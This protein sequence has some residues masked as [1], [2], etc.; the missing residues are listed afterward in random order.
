[1]HLEEMTDIC[2]KS[3]AD[4]GDNLYLAFSLSLI[5]GLSTIL[6]SF[7]PFLVPIEQKKFLGAGLGLAVQPPAPD[8][9]F[10]IYFLIQH[11]A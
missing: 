9:V 6:G 4:V 10:L 11:I 3:S 7:V 8:V 5:G 1:M 2:G